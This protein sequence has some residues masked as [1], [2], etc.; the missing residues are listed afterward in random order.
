[1]ISFGSMSN[2]SPQIGLGMF[3]SSTRDDHPFKLFMKRISTDIYFYFKLIGFQPTWQQKEFI[4]ALVAGE[5]NIA[6]R[7]GKGPGKTSVTGA[8]LPW[9]SLTRPYSRVVVT[10]PTMRQCKDVWLAE[11]NKWVYNGDKRIRNLYS[12]T[13]TGYGIMGMKQNRWGC[14]LATATSPEA[15][16]GI[17]NPN[18]LMYCEEASGIDRAIMQT[19]QDTLSGKKG[20]NVWV[21]VGNPNTRTCRFFD[22]FHSLAGN[23][24]TCL[25]W[26]AEETPLSDWFSGERNKEIEEEFGRDSDVYR[27]A[28][29]GEFPASDSTVLISDADLAKCYGKEALARAM[30]I[31]DS[32]KQ[33]GIDLARMGGDENVIAMRQGRMMIKMECYSR[34]DPN[35]A[36]DRAVLLQDQHTWKTEDTVYVVDTSGMGEAAVGN[37]GSKRRMGKRV[38]EFYSQNSAQESSKYANKITEAW[39]LFAKKVRTGELYL[40]ENPDRKLTLQLTS[41][42]YVVDN[43]GRIKIETKDEYKK[44][45]LDAGGSGLGDSPDRADGIVLAFYDHAHDSQRVTTA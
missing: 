2:K 39:C 10:A 17:H 6:V 43:K 1:M 37:L 36:I 32:K 9:W 45:N 14:Y 4:D 29:L 11:A 19:I 31:K 30:A 22:F 23:P 3:S 15:F 8:S 21:A 34:T 5:S 38:H 20:N 25:H 7:S 40:G 13:N 42:K 44:R 18:L 16:Q 28:V 12:F 27:I 26:N 35:Q 41:R 24:W 33:I